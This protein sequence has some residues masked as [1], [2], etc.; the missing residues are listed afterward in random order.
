MLVGEGDH[1]AL[2][3]PVCVGEGQMFRVDYQNQRE[4]IN[5]NKFSEKNL[6]KSHRKKHKK[7]NPEKKKD[8]KSEAEY[9]Y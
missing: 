2:I 6:R 9:F 1:P 8:R 7:K 4:V 5:K 3:P